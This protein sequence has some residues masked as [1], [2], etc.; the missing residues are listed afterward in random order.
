MARKPHMTAEQ[1]KRL[2]ALIAQGDDAGR[3]NHGL[4]E[5]QY[6]ILTRS[7]T[8]GYTLDDLR[9]RIRDAR[10]SVSLL[11]SLEALVQ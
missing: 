7:I 10:G 1:V 9:G 3:I 8:G 11:A 2:D 6:A 4:M 5:M